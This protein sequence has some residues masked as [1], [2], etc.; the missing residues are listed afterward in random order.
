M[1]V[2]DTESSNETDQYL[3][4]RTYHY[5]VGYINVGEDGDGDKVDAKI[6]LFLSPDLNPADLFASMVSGA[7]S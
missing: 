7:S 1:H 5:L 6:L 2:N 4:F 3:V